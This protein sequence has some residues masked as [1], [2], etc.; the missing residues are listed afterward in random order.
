MLASTSRRF[1]AAMIALL[2]AGAGL[3]ATT[4]SPAAATG[5]A[6]ITPTCVAHLVP[7]RIADP[8][9]VTETLW[10]ELC[11]PG[12]RRPST[13]QLLVHGGYANHGYW[14]SDVRGGYYSYVRAAVTAGY[15]TFN[16][17]RIGAGNSSHPHSSVVTGNAGAVALHDAITALRS[18]TLDG[19]AFS[20][21]I[22]VGHAVGSLHAWLEIPRYNDVDAAILTSALHA[23]NMEH[24]LT[25]AENVHPAAADPAFADSGLDR[26]YF[27]TKPGTRAGMFFHPATTDRAAAAADEAGK[28]VF[29]IQQGETAP[30]PHQIRVPVLLVAGQKDFMYCDGVTE[31]D[32]TRPETV[33]AFESQFYLPEARLQVVTIPLTGHALALS[34]SAPV[35]TAVMLKW[36]LRTA[37]P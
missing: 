22:W 6:G 29:P 30:L 15:A 20:K 19:H 26:G 11:Y 12:D 27:T 31:Y 17:D 36:A 37:A 18:G 21:V 9:P 13:V 10:G 7:V 1:L 34:T 32:C 3:I 5:P 14:A 25:V 4:A 35:T 28:D 33:R 8:G 23:Y 2:T 16:V 24:L